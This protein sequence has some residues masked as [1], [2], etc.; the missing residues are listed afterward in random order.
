MVSTLQKLANERASSDGVALVEVV[1]G[2]MV[3][4]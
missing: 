4:K 2:K 3:A 1:V